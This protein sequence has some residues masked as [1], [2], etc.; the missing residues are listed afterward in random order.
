MRKANRARRALEMGPMSRDV[1]N[2]RCIANAFAWSLLL[3]AAC[4]LA[5]HPDW[6]D[7]PLAK[8]I[9]SLTHD[10]DFANYMT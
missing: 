3:L 10:H 2:A 8:T 4:I 1:S 9:N 6:I 7:R 5:L